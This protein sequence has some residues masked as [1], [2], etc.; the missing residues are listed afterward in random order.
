MWCP[1]P[2]LFYSPRGTG[3][4]EDFHCTP[5]FAYMFAQTCP[6]RLCLSLLHSPLP[7]PHALAKACIFPDCILTLFHFAL[8]PDFPKTL[9]QD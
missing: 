9:I 4:I 3:N 7:V 6:P 1:M 5:H 2:L 8:C